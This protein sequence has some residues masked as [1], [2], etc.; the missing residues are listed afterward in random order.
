[1]AFLGKGL[2][3]GGSLSGLYRKILV[4]RLGT[5]TSSSQRQA[6]SI[7]G[8]VCKNASI[9]R[10][11]MQRYLQLS[12]TMTHHTHLPEAF[13]FLRVPAASFG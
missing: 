6:L 2:L 10:C 7:R 5:P 12:I 1:M 8:K 3:E 4:V 13:S 9:L 11:F